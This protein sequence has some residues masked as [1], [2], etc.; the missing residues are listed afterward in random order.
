MP[1]LLKKIDWQL[2]AAVGLL[3]AIGLASLLSTKPA[4][5]WHQVGWIVLG[6]GIAMLVASVDVRSFLG[7]R[8]FVV[9]IY[10]FSLFLLGLTYI[11]APV[12]KGNRAWIFIG[13]FQFQPSEFAKVA[14]IVML[15]YFFS[16]RHVG[17]AHWRTLLASLVYAGIPALIIAI[18][19][20]MGSAL[21]LGVVW[22][23]FV[24]FSGLPLRHFILFLLVAALLGAGM[25]MF[26]LK[27]YQKDRIMTLIDPNR[28]PLGASYNVIQSK[29]AIGSGG[30]WGKGFGQ[31]TQV[32]LGFLP[33]A[34]NDFI[35][36]AIAEEGGLVGSIILCVAF[37]WM[38][39]RLLVMG[40]RIDGNMGKFFCLGTAILFSAQFVFNVGSALGLFPVVGVTFPFVSYGGS[41]ITADFLLIGVAQSLYAKK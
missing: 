28:D 14:L 39:W 23:G 9:G 12:I 34:Q 11:F 4:L 31:G 2:N 3:A 35:V 33:E 30:I 6:V 8:S 41:S 17:I 29:I 25:W 19:P 24:V 22:F 10:V 26:G 7:R 16:K 5:F 27:G 1:L 18:Q 21:L 20:E 40:Q 13:P 15:S 37:L 38:M 36:A 32:Q